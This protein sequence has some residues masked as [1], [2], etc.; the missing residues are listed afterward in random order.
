MRM[1]RLFGERNQVFIG[2]LS[3]FIGTLS[4][5]EAGEGVVGLVGGSQVSQDPANRLCQGHCAPGR[6]RAPPHCP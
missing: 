2:T 4:L 1:S 5:C 6:A 3:L